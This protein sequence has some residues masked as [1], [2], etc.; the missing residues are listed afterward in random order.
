MSDDL[1]LTALAASSFS[2]PELREGQ[3]AGM[4]ALVER[5][6]V[7]AVMPTGYGKSATYQVAALYLH[8][9]TGRPAVVV[10]PL[11]ALQEDQLD[12]LAEHLGEGAGVAINSSRSDAEVEAA[13]QAVESGQAAFLFLAPEQLSKR[14]TVER[15]AN[16]DI[17][18]FVVDEA[19]CVSSWGHDFRPD[20]LELGHVRE[21]LGNPPVIALTATASPPVR[22]EIVKRLGMTEPVVLVRGFDRPNISLDVVRHQ[23]DKGKRKAVMEQVVALAKA[24]GLGL[25]YAATRKA[26]EKY[27]AKLTEHGLRA[28]AYHAGRADSDR[29]SIHERFLDDQLDVVVATTAFGMGIDKPNV[30]FV[31]HADIPESLDSYYQEIGRA[32]RDGEPATAILHYRA[33]D[34]GLRKFFATHSPDAEALTAVLKVIKNAGAPVPKTALVEL[35]GFPARRVTALVNQLEEAGAVTTGKRGTR[36]SSKAKLTTLVDRAVELAEARQRVDQSRLTMMRAYAETDACRRQFL[37]GYFGEDLPEP[38]GNCDACAEIHDDAGSGSAGH[39]TST[40]ENLFPL[41]STVIHKEWGP[42]LVMRHEDDVMTVLFEQEGYKTLSR[43]AVVEHELLKP[44]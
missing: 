10:S 38:C 33:E 44:A 12:G 40:A 19:H 43:A 7:L 24:E 8:N 32:G 34:L 11:I 42:G 29:E 25:L 28:E 6:D 16:L 3:L 2:L 14:E 5:R 13:W 1:A 30:R 15:I 18:M 23:E 39:L 9:K 20:Y 35:T 4:T 26:T 31:V 36:L 22:D 27:A 37:L 21:H 17:T 41:Q